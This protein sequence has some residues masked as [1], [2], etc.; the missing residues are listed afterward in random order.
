M[1]IATFGHISDTVLD[2]IEDQ[3]L[4]ARRIADAL[5]YDLVNN[6]PADVLVAE[7]A[8]DRVRAHQDEADAWEAHH[9]RVRLVRAGW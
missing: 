9:R 1:V 4:R 5:R 8:W 7:R 6:P 3:Y 2:A